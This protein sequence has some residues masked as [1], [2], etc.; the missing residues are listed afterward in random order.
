MESFSTTLVREKVIVRAHGAAT[1][2]DAG[3]TSVIRSNRLQLKIVRG[4]KTDLVVV[5]GH[6]MA[7]TLRFAAYAYR[8]ITQDK[9]VS[10]HEAIDWQTVYDKS[11]SDYTRAY[12]P[13][14][15][16]SV[17]INGDGVFKSA[18]SGVYVDVLE[19]CALLTGDT[20]E[21]AAGVTENVLR[22]AG[23][24][25]DL[26]QEVVV[27]AR[28]ED[29]G[30]R[31]RAS[32]IHRD[33]RNDATF[34]FTAV[35]GERLHRIGGTIEAAAAFL[36]GLDLAFTIGTIRARIRAGEI[37]EKDAEGQQMRVA[38]LRQTALNAIINNFESAYGVSYR[39]ERKQFH[40]H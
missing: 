3:V 22:E 36:E 19:K 18:E 39:P 2:A 35:N 7:N 24:P 1:D 37:T 11:K 38:S 30:I 21:D 26:H 34:S 17:H 20:Y 31:T 33:G 9:L 5:R 28:I 25:V 14:D 10:R 23:R 27:A 29:D 15:W 6:S 32:I 8:I 16:M 12:Q 40:I 13:D 4:D